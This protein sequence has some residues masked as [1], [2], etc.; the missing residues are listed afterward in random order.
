ME[1]VKKLLLYAK[2]KTAQASATALLA[3]SATLP[4]SEAAAMALRP[5]ACPLSL[6]ARNICLGCFNDTLF[7][8][9]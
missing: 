4:T 5:Q 7:V 1:A 6:L 9:F 8:L 2:L 3:S